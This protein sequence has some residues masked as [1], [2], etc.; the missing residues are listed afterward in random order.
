M[1]LAGGGAGGGGGA[2]AFAFAFAFSHAAGWKGGTGGSV[3]EVA[4]AG[5][6]SRGA[7]SHAAPLDILNAAS[8][9]SLSRGYGHG[10]RSDAGALAM[11]LT[12][13]T[14]GGLPRPEPE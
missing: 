5:G 13:G 14:V 2:F 7:F 1:D 12:G 4:G 8:E 9:A 6:E 11:Y 3:R 10:E